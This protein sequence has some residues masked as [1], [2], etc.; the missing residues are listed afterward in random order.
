MLNHKI[1]GEGDPIIIL[2]GLFGMLDNWLTVAKELSKDYM[3]IL[4]DLRNHGKSLHS[5]EWSIALMAKDV[6]DFLHENWIYEC[7]V[8]GHSMGGKVV[9]EMALQEADLVQKLIVVDIAPKA[10]PP[11]H[12]LIFQAL[13]AV[14]V[15]EVQS[16]NEVQ[17]VLS[18]YIPE[19]GV[20]LFL[21][22][23]LSRDKNG[24]FKWKMNLASISE[25]Y[26]TLIQPTRT[27]SQYDGP[28]LFLRGDHSNYILDEDYELINEIFP[29][30]TLK[31]IKD[32]GHWI[33]ADQKDVLIEEVRRFIE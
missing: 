1:I 7:I 2:H 32:A 25:N 12:A 26:E 11:G 3:V 22:K 14:P 33:H 13:H 30:S 16:R 23:N 9:M 29:N 8:I 19:P 4:I 20:H 17:E 28:T 18:K 24:G 5:E 21:M 31:T 27:D 10:Y 6:I 15:K